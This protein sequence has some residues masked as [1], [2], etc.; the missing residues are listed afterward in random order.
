MGNAPGLRKYHETQSP[1]NGLREKWNP[2][3]ESGAPA[4]HLLDRRRQLAM[5]F[6]HVEKKPGPMGMLAFI[7]FSCG[8]LAR[9][10]FPPAAEAKNNQSAYAACLMPAVPGGGSPTYP[11]R[12]EIRGVVTVSRPDG[13]GLAS[14]ECSKPRV[15]LHLA[16]GS[17]LATVDAAAGPTRTL[18]F[19]VRPSRN[20]R[21]LVLHF[22]PST[23]LLTAQ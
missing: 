22:H 20:A 15:I 11:V 16:P 8:V 1:S 6:R 2:D 5:A 4:R 7:A 10:A 23:P 13:S 18:R 12:L 3:D 14:V 17:Y 19:R 9:C 21:T